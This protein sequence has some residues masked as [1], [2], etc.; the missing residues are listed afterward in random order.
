MRSA[1][2]VYTCPNRLRMRGATDRNISKVILPTKFTAVTREKI[3]IRIPS[4]YVRKFSTQLWV[5]QP[6]GLG[7]VL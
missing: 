7:A 1:S 3:Q 5:W 4:V 2:R 6:E